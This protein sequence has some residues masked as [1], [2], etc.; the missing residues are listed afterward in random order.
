M[1]HSPTLGLRAFNNLGNT[2]FMS[3][4]L[5][6]LLRVA[7][8]QEYFLGDRHHSAACRS[9]KSGTDS[10]CLGASPATSREHWRR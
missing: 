3:S 9:H 4:V 10:V 8:L 2:C 6:A 5:H 1:P 7:P